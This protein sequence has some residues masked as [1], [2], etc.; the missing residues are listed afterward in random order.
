MDLRSTQ[1]RPEGEFEQRVLA[2]LQKHDARSKRE[3]QQMLSKFAGSCEIFNRAVNN[4]E[5]AEEIR[6]EMV[7]GK[8]RVYLTR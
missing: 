3:M 4:L 1:P 6:I 8:K 7:Q 5:R 2:W